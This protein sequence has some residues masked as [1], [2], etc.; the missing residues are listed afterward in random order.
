MGQ[1][2]IKIN[3]RDYDVA[4]ADGEED[5]VSALAAQVSVRVEQLAASVGQLGEARM[6]L[7]AC[8][9]LADELSESTKN[10][11]G[12]DTGGGDA[13]LLDAM[14]ERIERIAQSLENA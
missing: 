3:G 7:M 9:V 8:L 10:G 11:G 13:K 5:H 2:S 14:S 12:A 4:C 1:V 6:L